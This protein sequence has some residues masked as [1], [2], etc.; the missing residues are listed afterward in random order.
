[1]AADHDWPMVKL[2]DVCTSVDRWRKDDDLDWQYI[3][4]SSIESESKSIVGPSTI[5]STT[6][7]SRATTV[8]QAGDVL[9]STVR[10]NLNAVAAVPVSLSP[11][12]AS[13][14]LSVLRT[15]PKI[16]DSRYLFHVVQTPGFIQ[17]ACDLAT[18][19]SYPAVSD[20]KIRTIQIPV[21]PLSE[22]RR[23]A[24]ILDTAQLA[25]KKADRSLQLYEDL[26]AQMV[27]S[28]IAF[29]EGTAKL[30]DLADLTGGLAL[31]RKRAELP[32][33][34]PYLR[35]ANV[36]RNHI[37]FTELK[38]LGCTERELDRT[39]LQAGDIL[40]TEAHGNVEEVGRAARL[41]SEVES[42]T[43]QNH[44][45]RVRSKGSVPSL[46]LSYLINSEPVRR[47]LRMVANT[48]SGLNTISI[49][50]A[51]DL[52]IPVLNRH[53]QQDLLRQLELVEEK[54]RRALDKAH[55][56]EELHASLSARAFAGKL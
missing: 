52:T 17:R 41:T 50:K 30:S 51:R 34:V 1:M 3:D 18:G 33:Q 54:K 13:S 14:G 7:P 2:G 5:T 20:S 49:S 40:M 36:F 27:Q 11:S 4:I 38:A 29:R 9:V 10:P 8:T 45:F 12:I 32:L 28:A 55:K 23:I 39:S 42:L 37:D 24:K 19:A 6:A 35:V 31:S 46:V 25:S 53:D 15:D 47:Q 56:L 22:Q 21:P 16:A 26:A 44:L 48:T 43:Y